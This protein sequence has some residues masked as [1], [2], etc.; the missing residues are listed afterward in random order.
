MMRFL[1][2]VIIGY[3]GLIALVAIFQRR[4]IY[5]PTRLPLGQAL[6]LAERDGFKPVRLA[7]REIIG[8]KLSATDQPVATVLI[9]HGNAGCALDRD[10]FAHPIAEAMPVDVIVVEYPG[11]GPREGSPS[12]S[13]ILTTAEAAMALVPTNQPVFLV[14][15]SIGAGAAAHLARRFPDRIHG[16]TMFVPYDDLSRVA[17]SAMPFLPARW[18]L[19]DRF[20][21]ADWLKDFRHPAQIVLA[22]ADE[23]IPSKRGQT[24]YD[25]YAGPKRLQIVP[26]AR[27]NDVGAQSPDWW[28]EVFGFLKDERANGSTR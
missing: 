9:F 11:Y 5:F 23:V 21:P 3:A 25:G 17:Q 28:R 13:T 15:E 8:W 20:K 14:S 1:W 16:M 6:T 22:G 4:L 27:H 26:G 12:L 24:L 10:Y 2:L 18:L 7:A 19:R